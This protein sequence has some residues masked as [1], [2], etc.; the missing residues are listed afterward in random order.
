MELRDL[1]YFE[2]IATLGHMGRAAERLG[3]TQPALSKS[4][5][6]LEDEIG[7]ELFKRAGRGIALTETGQALLSRARAIRQN[8]DESIREVG[9]LARGLTG[10]IRVGCGATTAEYILPTVTAKLLEAAPD[11]RME[12]MIGMND[13]LRSSLLDGRL[14]LSVGPIIAGD[15][16]RFDTETFGMDSVVAA[17]ARE[18][19]LAAS[20]PKLADLLD[21]GWV[22]PARS[23]AT[24]QWL[25]AAFA[26]RGLSL[27]RVNILSNNLSLSPRLVIATD[28]IT[29]ISRRNLSPGATGG[30]LV[31]LD[32][33]ELIMRRPVGTIAPKLAY[34]SPLT[35]RFIDILEREARQVLEQVAQ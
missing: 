8:V 26:S 15:E 30:Q 25:E 27:P 28:L 17:V 4:I 16:E 10:T 7:A 3:R 33:P 14:D 35:R 1:A 21:Y 32:V 31:E 19:R 34:R 29:F 20:T 11:V 13:V 6:R 5:R 22:L 18:H 9:D 24:R 23:V 2:T 12:V